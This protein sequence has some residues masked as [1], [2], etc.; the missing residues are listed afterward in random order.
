[1]NRWLVPVLAGVLATSLL[2]WIAFRGSGQGTS[3]VSPEP[4]DG[5]LIAQPTWLDS[6]GQNTP[7]QQHEADA[8]GVVPAPP[9]GA[10]ELLHADLFVRQKAFADILKQGMEAFGLLAELSRHPNDRL[11]IPGVLGIT[12]MCTR[13]VRCEAVLAATLSHKRP[14]VVFLAARGLHI[15]GAAAEDS[16]PEL[17]AAGDTTDEHAK[18]MCASAAFHIQRMVEVKEALSRGERLD[19]FLD[20]FQI[21]RIPKAPVALR[22][23]MWAWSIWDESEREELALFEL[24]CLDRRGRLAGPDDDFKT[25]DAE[26]VIE[27]LSRLLQPTMRLIEGY[28]ER[29]GIFPRDLEALA[30][31]R[32]WEA[33]PLPFGFTPLHGGDHAELRYYELDSGR[34]YRVGGEVRYAHKGIMGWRDWTLEFLF[35]SGE[36]KEHPRAGELY[37]QVQDHGDWTVW[38]GPG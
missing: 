25:V 33:P 37:E 6:A 4:A 26:I 23:G 29:Y 16:I 14:A 34:C 17:E 19:V 36:F 35:G 5:P 27:V 3:P 2:V 8:P 18:W 12:L 21:S 10:E 32:E 31:A 28:Q 20:E 7:Q 9:V 30:A 11:A 24:R 13:E 1:M 15:M 22:G 38:R